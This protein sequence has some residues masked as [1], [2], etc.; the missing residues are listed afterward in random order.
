MGIGIK[1]IKTGSF[2]AIIASA[3]PRAKMAPEAPIPIERGYARKIKRIFPTMPPMKY[4]I[5]KFLSP[6][7]LSKKLPKKYRLIILHKIWPKPPWT[8][9]LVIIVQGWC[10]RFAG[11]KPR[12]KTASGL[13]RVTINIKMFKLIKNQRAFKLKVL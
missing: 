12:K 8:K 1:N 6:I 13:A 11:C 10:R 3:P 2:G 4:T 7:S 5:R 9:R